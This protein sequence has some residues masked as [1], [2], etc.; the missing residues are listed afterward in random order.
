MR[1]VA[2]KA[3]D[4]DLEPM[5][6]AAASAWPPDRPP[7]ET[8]RYEPGKLTLAAAGWS[9]PQIAQFKSLLQPAGWQVDA[10]GTQIVL[11]RA[12]A[13]ARS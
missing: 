10:N 4:A 11:S 8:L 5:L 2:G 9:E 3:G 12:R 6:M 1:S 7:V 13:G